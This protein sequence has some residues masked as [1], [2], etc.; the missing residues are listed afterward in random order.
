MRIET[1]WFCGANVYPGHG[2]T[3]VRN[4]A[5]I[6]RFCRGRCRKLFNKKRDP[7]KLA[8]TK[9]YRQKNG[10]ELLI[11]EAFTFEKRRNCPVRYDRDLMIN[12]VQAMKRIEEI[13]KARKER[14]Y[15]NR[16]AEAHQRQI[17]NIKNEL[18]RHKTLLNGVEVPENFDDEMEDEKEM[19]DQITEF[20]KDLNKMK[21]DEELEENEVE[22]AIETALMEKISKRNS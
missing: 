12:T 19:Q 10:K 14:F 22:K 11:D 9:A 17:I 3:F 8:W 6:F 21:E 15:A 16:M 20:E 18:K 1:C 2:I 4:D 7:R 5:K 13:K